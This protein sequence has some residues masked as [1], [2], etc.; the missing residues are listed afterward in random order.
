MLACYPFSSCKFPLPIPYAVTS[1]LP[2][3]AR[4][5]LSDEYYH[6]DVSTITPMACFYDKSP[7]TW[8]EALPDVTQ[9]AGGLAAPFQ[10]VIEGKCSRN[11]GPLALLPAL[12]ASTSDLDPLL[13][14]RLS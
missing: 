1:S 3:N 11:G 4:R 8:V 14:P 10:I 12:D 9:S 2:L 13:V 6:E 5:L 7:G